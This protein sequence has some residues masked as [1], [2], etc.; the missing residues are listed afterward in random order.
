M[1]RELAGSGHAIDIFTSEELEN[2]SLSVLNCLQDNN[3]ELSLI[4]ELVYYDK[5]N[6]TRYITPLRV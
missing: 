4:L 5:A 2:I 3:H 6:M 1:L